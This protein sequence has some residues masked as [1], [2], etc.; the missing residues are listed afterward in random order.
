MKTIG[1]TLSCILLL[2]SCT[3]STHDHHDHAQH[4][5]HADGITY[6]CP[7]HPDVVQDKPGSCPV[8]GMDLVEV[9][10]T[11]DDHH[12]MLTNTQLRLANI[13][14]APVTMQRVGRTTVVNAILTVDEQQSGVI[15]SRASGR[16]E[17][18]FVKETGRN[19]RQGEPLYTLYSEELLTLQQEYLL[20]KEQYETL[21]QAE[22]RYKSFF[23]AARRKLL[24]LGLTSSQ[25]D[26]LNQSSL[27]PEVVFLAPQSGT[28]SEVDI[29]EGMYVTE[30]SPLFRIEDTRS[31]W[32]EAELYP[33]EE[34]LV[35][36]GDTI[37]VTT[38]GSSGPIQSTVIFLSPEF[39]SNT[40]VT[41][42]RARID[43]PDG[44]LR[45]G[46]FAQVYLTQATHSALA[47][48]A[49]AVIRDEHGARVYLASEG[50]AF[51]PQPV[52][53]GLEGPDLIEVTQGLLEGD[54]IA[55]T[56]AYLLHSE[57]VLK[58]GSDPM[59]GH[60]H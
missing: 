36:V 55:V 6:T 22:P 24:L 50:H 8:C 35:R 58:Q 3:T 28:I 51:R 47:V 31:L 4:A 41:I 49:D 9:S 17:K 26:R 25:I 10:H 27:R 33:G 53:I 11:G 21:G 37:T 30:G 32:V 57:F 43:N 20:A 45:A 1:F 42:L 38:E 34:A 54:T 44:R 46:Q 13:T 12:I 14:L 16:V 15:S 29:V 60:T 23:D 5:E 52:K 39:R 2:A 19:V 40:Q 18:I 56:G 7:M 48:P 59:A